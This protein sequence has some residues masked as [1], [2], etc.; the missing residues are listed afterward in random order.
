MN[1]IAPENKIL[2]IGDMSGASHAAAG[3]NASLDRAIM[4]KWKKDIKMNET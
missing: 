4:K 3:I 2:K 1:V